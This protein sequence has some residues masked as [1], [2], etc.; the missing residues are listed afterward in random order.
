MILKPQLAGGNQLAIY[1]HWRGVK[2]RTTT[3][4]ECMKVDA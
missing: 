3:Y 4:L 2:L 1:K